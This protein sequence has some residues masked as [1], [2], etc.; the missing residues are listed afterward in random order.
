MKSYILYLHLRPRNRRSGWKHGL[1]EA[2]DTAIPKSLFHLASL[3][4]TTREFIPTKW[5][6][7]MGNKQGS[8]ERKK[9]RKKELV[10]LAF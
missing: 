5:L 6:A 9:E 1:Y 7:T 2:D 4:V 8:Q 3:A 10:P